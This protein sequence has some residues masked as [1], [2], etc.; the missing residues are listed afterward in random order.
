MDSL[1][2]HH[3]I[4]F[5]IASTGAADSS[6]ITVVEMISELLAPPELRGKLSSYIDL[7]ERLGW[8][9]SVAVKQPSFDTGLCW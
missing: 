3:S 1:I 9:A 8:P 4:N 7:P 5:L 2:S 6:S